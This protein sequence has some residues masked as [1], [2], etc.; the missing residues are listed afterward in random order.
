MDI[1][2]D[3]LEKL[4]KILKERKR[5]PIELLNAVLKLLDFK[6]VEI[7]L[8]NAL[9]KKQMKMNELVQRLNMSERSIRTHIKTLYKKGFIKR[10]ALM[11]NRLKYVYSSVTPKIAWKIVKKRVNETLNQVDKIF[12]KISVFL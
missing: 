1:S 7:K 3:R 6:K 5:K 9:L 11:G 4:Q 12:Q 2:V 10:K 8:Y